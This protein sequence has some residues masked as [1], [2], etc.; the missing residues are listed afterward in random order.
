MEREPSANASDQDFVEREA[1]LA[2]IAE[3][4][5]QAKRVDFT[6]YRRSTIERR[7]RQRMAIRKVDRLD[8]YVHLLETDPDEAA[9]L[10]DRFLILTTRFFRDKESFEILQQQFLPPFF[11]AH[12]ADEP[13]R[14]WSAGC[15]TGEEAYSIAIVLLEIAGA[16]P[17]NVP[18][19]VFASDVSQL[20]LERARAGVFSS[21]IGD[22]VSA[23]RLERFFTRT[24][25]GYRI[26]KA[27]R[28]LCIFARHDLIHD[29]PFSR[30]DAVLCR[31]VLIY[32]D[33][34]LQ[35]VV[36]ERLHYAMRSDGILMIGQGETVSRAPELFE[37]LNAQHK[38][39]GKV[40]GVQRPP[41]F[42]DV[43][44][45]PRPEEARPP[46]PPLGS[47]EIAER[48][49]RLLARKGAAGVLVDE[50]FRIVRFYGHTGHYLEPPPGKPTFDVLAMA[51]GDLAQVLREALPRAL[52]SGSA[53]IR[54]DI[55]IG[56]GPAAANRVGVE[57]LRL[58][59]SPVHLL[60][61]FHG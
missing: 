11:D 8:A 25:R 13:L 48:G 31:N 51:R 27:V 46:E 41:P 36:L 50:H 37:I 58:D 21:R 61:I 38:I 7:L 1:L 54:N 33:E 6:G 23:E 47:P 39:F 16:R 5:Y 17:T 56:S 15:S 10:I 60:V 2:R 18:I 53:V 12:S 34:K 52:A 3:L 43:V 42:E 14:V 24:D 26:R 29:P 20:A 49:R 32:M 44:A 57:V 40:P 19:Q 28:E 30:I 55:Q 22:D 45:P 35:R 59:G 4:L 9:E